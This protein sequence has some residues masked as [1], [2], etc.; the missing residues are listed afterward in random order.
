MPIA[1]AGSCFAQH[2][3]RGLISRQCHFVDVEPAPTLMQAGRA[4]YGFELFSA[5]FGNI[6]TAAQLRQ[7]VERA[8]GELPGADAFWVQDNRYYDP[9]RPTI[10][11]NGFAS[12]EE[13]EYC[14]ES[15]LQAVRGLFKYTGVFVFTLGLTEAWMSIQDGIV[16]PMCP[17][18]AAG[19]FDAS[20]HQFVNYDTADVI[21]DFEAF[22]DIVLGVNPS[23]K[24]VL[25]VSPVPLVA[26]ATPQHVINATSYSK[27]VLRAAAGY[28]YNT[29]DMVDY[30][31]SYEIFTSPVFQGQFYQEDKRSPT[32]AGVARAMSVFFGQH[33]KG[34]PG[35]VA[36]PV[37]PLVTKA[38]QEAAIFAAKQR[39][40]CD[41]ILLEEELSD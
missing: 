7:L 25:T 36:A 13:L 31:P 26:T 37:A 15:H 6:Y 23:I 38:V 34:D 10:E 11:P 21:R 35:T 40:I 4:E 29:H 2:I 24:F 30:F 41:E 20:K 1:T 16:Y 3:R 8:F 27:S 17:G 32:E 14:R 28:L 18:T 19:E 39:E 33:C 9:F 22:M 5:R 12:L